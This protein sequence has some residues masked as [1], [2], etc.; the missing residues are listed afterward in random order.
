MPLPVSPKYLISLLDGSFKSFLYME[1]AQYSVLRHD[2]A[3]CAENQL[4]K[5]ERRV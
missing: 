4:A 1:T 2:G 3:I 5:F